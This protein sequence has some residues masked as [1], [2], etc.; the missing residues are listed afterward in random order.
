MAEKQGKQ[1]MLKIKEGIG[2]EMQ[3]RE[4]SG[5]KCRRVG[6]AKRPMNV[7]ISIRQQTLDEERKCNAAIKLL[8]TE[9][10]RQQLGCGENGN[11]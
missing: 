1:E 3:N 6:G 7:A 2:A 10:V 11:E 5:A 9:M 8:L 4:E